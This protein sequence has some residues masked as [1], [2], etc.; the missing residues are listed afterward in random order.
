MHPTGP[1]PRPNHPQAGDP[2]LCLGYSGSQAESGWR[3]THRSSPRQHRQ[4]PGS[5]E[6][7]QGKLKG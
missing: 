4:A 2:V 1:L 6:A 5:I 7:Q 3:D